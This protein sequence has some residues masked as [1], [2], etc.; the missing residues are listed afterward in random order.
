MDVTDVMDILEF[1]RVKKIIFLKFDFEF[2]LT[3]NLGTNF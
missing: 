1:R 2:I 3:K